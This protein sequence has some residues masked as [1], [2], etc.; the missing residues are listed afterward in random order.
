[1]DLNSKV[2]EAVKDVAERLLNLADADLHD[3]VSFAIFVITSGMV[4]ET[5][6]ANES[7]TCFS[8]DIDADMSAN[9][10]E[11]PAFVHKMR[12]AR[13]EAV[14]LQSMPPVKSTYDPFTNNLDKNRKRGKKLLIDAS[15]AA[16]N[17]SEYHPLS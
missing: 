7:T 15:N 6:S 8:Q 12:S 2:K 16:W 9:R 5:F 14:D 10:L 4:G 13:I 17:S 11:V 1:M 3:S